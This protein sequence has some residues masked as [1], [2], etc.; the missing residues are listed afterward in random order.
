MKGEFR[1]FE[2]SL[3]ELSKTVS[4]SKEPLTQNQSQ[5]L[6]SSLG[7]WNKKS[8]S[9]QEYAN[10]LKFMA[11]LKF[12]TVQLNQ[13]KIIQAIVDQCLVKKQQSFRWFALVLTGMRGLK[14]SG[15]LLQ[16]NHRQR[17]LDSLSE[18]KEDQHEK[19]ILSY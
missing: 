5:Q 2:R 16:N 12:S 18:L 4:L 9:Q 19:R 7:E 6:I 8:H 13:K 17:I 10:I 15:S 11:N 14:Y 1:K 3:D